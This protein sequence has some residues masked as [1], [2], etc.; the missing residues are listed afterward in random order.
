[1]TADVTVTRDITA[2]P[3][4]LW[5]L[6]SD[7]PRMGEWSPENTGGSWTGGA[8]GATTGAKFVSACPTETTTS[9]VPLNEPSLAVS[10][11]V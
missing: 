11:R 5:N 8:T 7:L 1:M 2:A 3:E 10:R 9:S 6:I 4:V